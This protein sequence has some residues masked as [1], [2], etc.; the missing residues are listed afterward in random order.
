MK[1]SKM[2]R[3]IDEVRQTIQNKFKDCK[4]EIVLKELNETFTELRQLKSIMISHLF[5]ML[6]FAIGFLICIFKSLVLGFFIFT[7]LLFC[8][9]ILSSQTERKFEKKAN[10]VIQKIDHFFS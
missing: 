1:I 5:G 9:T 3:I 6:L 8:A 2:K 10:E 4:E 7:L